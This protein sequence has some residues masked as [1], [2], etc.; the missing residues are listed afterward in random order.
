LGRL[1]GR[2]AVR[3][4]SYRFGPLQ[5]NTGEESLARNG[6]RVKVQDLNNAGRTTRRNC[7]PRGGPAIK[8]LRFDLVPA[9]VELAIGHL[10][11]LRPQLQ[12]TPERARAHHFLA[13]ELEARLALAE[14]KKKLGQMLQSVAR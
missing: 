11:E 1:V 3:R 14:L 13:V 6:L 5:L 8:R 12:S 7:H 10:T 2:N 9:R 4:G